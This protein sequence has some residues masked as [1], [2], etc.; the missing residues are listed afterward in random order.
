MKKTLFAA[1]LL[2]VCVLLCVS[3][4]QPAA[5]NE[6]TLVSLKITRSPEKTAYTAGESFEKAGMVVVGVYSDGEEKE[7]TAY[8]V[9]KTVLTGEDTDVTISYKGI[10]VVQPITV[11]AASVE[12]TAVSIAVQTPPAKVA[13][14]AGEPFDKTGMVVVLQYSDGSFEEVTDYTVDQTILEEGD[15]AVTVTYQAFTATQA[16]T[17]SALPE[18]QTLSLV[19]A[20]VRSLYVAGECFD[21]T[22]ILLC[23]TAGENSTLTTVCTY[24]AAALTAGT[25]HVTVSYGRSQVE[26]PVTVVAGT[27]RQFP[28]SS[29]TQ[30]QYENK[31]RELTSSKA[32][33]TGIDIG[34][35]YNGQALVNLLQ[36]PYPAGVS[37]FAELLEE[38]DYHLFY[39]MDSMVIKVNYAYGD[40]E[41]TLDQLYFESGFVGACMS[42]E[43]YEIEGGY[44][45]IVVKYYGNTL[46]SVDP[47]DRIPTYLEFSYKESTRPANYQFAKIDAKSGI[48][49]YNSEQALYALTHGHKIYPVPGSAAASIVDLAKNILIE[50]CDD[51]MSAYQKMYNIYYYITE[52]TVYDDGEEWAGTPLDIAHESDMLSARLVS[53]RAEGP[54]MYGNAACYGYAKAAT[55][56]LGLE[57]F[58]VTRVVAKYGSEISGRSQISTATNTGIAVHSYCYVRVDGYDYLMDPTYAVA[59]SPGLNGVACVWYR[60]FCVG[61][62][63]EEHSLVYAGC[64]ADAYCL[65]DDYNPAGF[66]VWA[67]SRY[68]GEHD[69]LLDD[70]TEMYQCLEAIGAKITSDES[71]YAFSFAVKANAFWDIYDFRDQATAA[72]ESTFAPCYWYRFVRE[73]WVGGESYYALFMITRRM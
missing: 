60:D 48:Y 20:P 54:L 30:A 50:C 27:A 55:L 63:K 53:F 65:R 28:S 4:T 51:S 45:Q 61:M 67:N 46:I 1:L 38:M 6:P 16:V 68:D 31:I 59:G 71:F 32:V 47:T 24:P 35:S 7:I 21:P 40:L 12:K 15:T 8:T 36:D 58:E 33:Q 69:L 66:N 26:V 5:Q 2:L 10:T 39:G 34:L 17:V 19:N 41:E 64:S 3:C 72:A 23:V 14:T 43:G 49:V 73:Y 11:S 22:G 9:N 56:L 44:L 42:I 25:D 62:S 37:S 29:Y 57:G 13:Y 70:A 18:D 52:H